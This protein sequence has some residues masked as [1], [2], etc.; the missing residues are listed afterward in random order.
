MC[1]FQVGQQPGGSPS[2]P[3]VQLRELKGGDEIGIDV[4]GARDMAISRKPGR[5]ELL[6]L[7]RAFRGSLP[8]DFRFDRDEAMPGSVFDTAILVDLAA[9]DARKADRAEALVAGSGTISV[10]V[11]NELATIARRKMRLS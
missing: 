1:R 10:Q 11:L 7:L 9:D 2:R 6:N 5:E 3:V 8:A 4:A